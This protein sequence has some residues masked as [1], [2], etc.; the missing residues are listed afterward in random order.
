MPKF[1]ANTPIKHDGADV[2]VDDEIELTAKAAKPLLDAGAIRE[3]PAAE[4]SKKAKEKSE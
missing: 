3:L 1:L 4:Q 2:G